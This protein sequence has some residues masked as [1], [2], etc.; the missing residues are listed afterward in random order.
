MQGRIDSCINEWKRRLIDLTRR[1]RLIYFVPK[2]SSSIQIAEPTPSEVF[3][4]FVIDEKALKCFIPEEDEEIDETVTQSILPIGDLEEQLKSKSRRL[5][6]SDEII[7]KTQE[8]RVLKSVLR[9]LERRSRS[10]FEERGVRILH[11]AFGILE[12]QE[13]EQSESVRSPLLLVPVELKRKS[14]L[15]PYEIWPTDEEIVINPA[16]EVKL[17]NDFRIDLPTLPEDW[18]EITLDEYLQ[19]IMRLV[20]KRGWSVFQECWIGLFSFHKLVIY[21]DLNTH[22]ELMWLPLALLR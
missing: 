4:R 10:D 15:D 13:V 6:R 17:H 12:W 3:N 5:R 20:N 16:L 7:C 8:T 22:H 11:L 18:E 2:R 9:N 19:K 1:N 21:Q 14:V